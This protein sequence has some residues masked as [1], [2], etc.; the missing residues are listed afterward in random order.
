MVAK[1]RDSQCNFDVIVLFPVLLWR[2]VNTLPQ[3]NAIRV[4]IRISLEEM[5]QL[6]DIPTRHI[7]TFFVQDSEDAGDG[8]VG[9]L[10][11]G[12]EQ[13]AADYRVNKI[14]AVPEAPFPAEVGGRVY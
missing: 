6:R 5:V 14:A 11:T 8:G 1:S 10:V 13:F 12:W 2:R 9:Q 4:Q 3:P 7:C